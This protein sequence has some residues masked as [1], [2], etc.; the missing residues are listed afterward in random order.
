MT[1]RPPTA[2]DVQEA[3]LRFAGGHNFRERPVLRLPL[4]PPMSVFD[5]VVNDDPQKPTAV[6]HCEVMIEH[7]WLNGEPADRLIGSVPGTDISVVL[8]TRIRR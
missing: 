7:G 3:W 4:N 5:V 1:Q 8:D 2:K 6:R